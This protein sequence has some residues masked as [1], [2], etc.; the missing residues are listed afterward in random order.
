MPPKFK[1]S[2]C[3]VDLMPDEVI[4]H[5]CMIGEGIVVPDVIGEI[6]AFRSWEIDEATGL[7][8]SLNGER[9]KPDGWLI[10]DCKTH[11]LGHTVSN[12]PVEGCTC[13]I[14]AAKTREHLADMSYNRYHPGMKRVIGE[15]ALA[16]KV[17]PGTQ[18]YRA[19][20]ARPTKIFVPYEYWQL[21]ALLEHTYKIP[22]ELDNTLR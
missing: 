8:L 17:I 20:K 10:A 1:C 3:G 15:V 16:G 9:W 5:E 13:G 4:D 12:I 19:L 2:E 18:G 22:V 14:Y 7:L 6:T 11:L 21:V